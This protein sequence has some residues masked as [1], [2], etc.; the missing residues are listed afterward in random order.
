MPHLSV[1]HSVPAEGR[2]VGYMCTFLTF[3]LSLEKG[4]FSRVVSKP[5]H[6][7][8][9]VPCYVSLCRSSHVCQLMVFCAEHTGL[10]VNGV[11]CSKRWVVS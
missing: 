8:C 5:V 1:L 9:Y 7:P 6:G 2:A 4:R 10:S 11:L 3:G